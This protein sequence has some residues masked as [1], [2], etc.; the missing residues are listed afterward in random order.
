MCG[1]VRILCGLNHSVGGYVLF[2]K[3][4]SGYSVV[5]MGQVSVKLLCSRFEVCRKV[6]ENSM[7]NK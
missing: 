6:G 7:L 5:L 2:V 1:S 4:G 3:F